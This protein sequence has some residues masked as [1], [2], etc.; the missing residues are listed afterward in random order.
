MIVLGGFSG[1]EDSGRGKDSENGRPDRGFGGKPSGKDVSQFPESSTPSDG[2]T[3]E[4]VVLVLFMGKIPR[5]F[6]SRDL[7]DFHMVMDFK[8]E[9]QAHEVI[10][11]DEQVPF[12]IKDLQ[13]LEKHMDKPICRGFLGF[14]CEATY[15][16][17]PL[18][19]YM[20]KVCL[21]SEKTVETFEREAKIITSIR[22][23][24]VARYLAYQVRLDMP[25]LIME[26][27]PNK[28]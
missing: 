24:N 11:E 14:Y 1:V 2:K 4:Q 12:H 13:K 17:H 20:L 18:T 6:K 15:E 8:L 7:P 25:F 3:E 19:A 27:M 28:T 23:P 10:P 26:P 16:K 21:S 9:E 5:K 22:H